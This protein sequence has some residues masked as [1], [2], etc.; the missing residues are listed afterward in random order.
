[1]QAE[2]A[3]LW[4]ACF[5]DA[6]WLPGKHER[7]KEAGFQGTDPATDFRGGGIY[8]LRNLNYFAEQHPVAFQRLLT[9]SDGVRSDMEYPFCVAGAMLCK[10]F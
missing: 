2:L 5:P 6:P 8:S 4:K 7:W 10:C 1:M 9:K 3:T